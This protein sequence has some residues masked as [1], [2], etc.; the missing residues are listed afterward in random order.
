MRYVSWVAHKA[1]TAAGA[2]R[3]SRRP[4]WVR[5][6]RRTGPGTMRHMASALLG[7]T[8]VIGVLWLTVGLRVVSQL[9]GIQYGSLWRALLHVLQVSG[10]PLFRGGAATV[11]QR[12]PGV[13]G[14]LQ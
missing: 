14:S 12:N 7:D 11:P 5:S 1:S 9:S 13:S 10:A 8:S 3:I 4:P 2:K 6:L